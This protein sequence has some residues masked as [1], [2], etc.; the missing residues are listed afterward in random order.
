M[1]CE[2]LFDFPFHQ[3]ILN[4]RLGMKRDRLIDLRWL[5]LLFLLSAKA[6]CLTRG[7]D[8]SSPSSFHRLL[9]NYFEDRLKFFP[10]EATSIGDPRYNAELPVTISDSHREKQKAFYARYE[11]ELRR[12]DA[13]AL[14]ADDRISYEVLE[15][16]LRFDLEHLD[17]LDEY[18]LIHR[19]PIQQFASYPLTFMQ[20][21]TG[22]EKRPFKSVKVYDDW[23]GRMRAFHRWAETAVKIMRKNAKDGWTQPKILMQRVLDQYAEVLVDDP[24]KSTFFLPIKN[25][26]AVIP[27]AD[28]RR[29]ETAYRKAI[30]TKIVPAFRQLSDF[31]RAE[32]LPVCRTSAGIYDVP[33]G[34]V[35]YEKLVKYWT[36]TDMTPESIHQLGLSEVSRIRTEMEKVKRQVGFDGDLKSF[37]QKLRSDPQF[38]PYKTDEDVLNAFRGILAR[39]RPHLSEEF[40]IQPSTR[41]EIRATESFRAKTAS[42]EYSAPSGDGSRPGIFYVP[43]PEPTKFNAMRNESL[44]LHEAIPGH[45]FQIALQQ[46]NSKLPKF[47]RFLWFGAFGEGWALYTDPYQY[48]GMLMAEMHRAIRLV[49]DTGMHAKRW[50][51]EQAIQFTLDNESASEQAAVAEIERYMALPGQALSYKIGQLKILELRQRAKSILGDKFRLSDYHDEVLRDG[52]LPLNIFETKMNAWIE[53]QKK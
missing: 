8:I 42:A 52:V 41:F 32:Y 36:T 48:L 29:L 2:L 10:T 51:R 31:I 11:R 7:A 21:G 35:I 28:R 16:Q 30:S 20:E 47:R 39:I 40:G 24:V 13:T 17:T 15:S 45:H 44:F 33:D 1:R 4:I 22:S 6:I 49:V 19:M 34:S 25:F 38:Q 27:E 9:D 12:Y 3:P 5:I 37:F 53:R 50:T 14:T 23:L 43:I 26:P 46:E 18:A